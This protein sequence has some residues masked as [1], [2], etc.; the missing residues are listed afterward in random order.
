[1]RFTPVLAVFVLAASVAF[2]D[3]CPSCG[4][5]VPG[6]ANFCPKCG[7]ARAASN[8]KVEDAVIA[9]EEKK[10]EFLRSLEK[11]KKAY[12][13]AGN[14][15]RAAEIDDL[16]K[17]L[18]DAGLGADGGAIAGNGGA[19]PKAGGK[20]IKEANDLYEQAK[21]YM[22]TINP[23]RR[24]G[25]YGIAIDKLREIIDKYPDS[26]KVL[27]AWYNLGV[28]YSDGFV[29]RYEDAVKAFDR[30]KE[31]DPND[32]GDSRI[33]AAKIVDNL[34]RYKEAYDRYQD[35]IDHDGNARNVEWAKARRV[36]LEP[37]VK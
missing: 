33:L 34:K 27:T 17:G 3:P 5:D 16:I 35:V 10:E 36:K 23:A 18:A 24:G 13:E 2:A 21:L 32:S 22:Q 7:A 12:E 4:A 28:C 26:D 1:M 19:G 9:A 29:K 30:V 31:I 15:K 11:L 25:N 6:D 37:Y 20:S 14:A 8:K